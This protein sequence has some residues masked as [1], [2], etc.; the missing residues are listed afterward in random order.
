[1]PRICVD[2]HYLHIHDGGEYY[3]GVRGDLIGVVLW[4]RWRG[5]TISV[6]DQVKQS[7][8]GGGNGSQCKT[9]LRGV[10]EL[11]VGTPSI[12]TVLNNVNSSNL[13]YHISISHYTTLH[14]S[15]A[16]HS[17]VHKKHI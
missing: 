9:R 4:F 16:A 14:I 8:V 3:S 10:D 12:E 5:S 11:K 7:N 15:Y 6:L 1:M 2:L 13:P 17:N